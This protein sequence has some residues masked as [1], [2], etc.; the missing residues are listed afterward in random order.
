MKKAHTTSQRK[1]SRYKIL[2]QISKSIPR[3]IL[4]AF[5][6]MIWSVSSVYA[7][8]KPLT[9]TFAQ[10][11][12]SHTIR[13]NQTQECKESTTQMQKIPAWR[14]GYKLTSE[15]ILYSALD[16]RCKLDSSTSYNLKQGVIT[17]AQGDRIEALAENG[18]FLYIKAQMQGS[19]PLFGYIYKQNAILSV[20]NLDFYITFMCMVGVLIVGRYIISKSRFLRDYNI[21]EPVIGGIVVAVLILCIYQFGHIEFKFDSSLRDP[22]MLAFFSSIG[23][24]AD[25]ASLRKGGKM[26]C[27][28]LVAVVGLLALQ[29]IIGVSVASAM[30]VNPLIGMLGGSITMSGGHGTGAAWAEAFRNKYHLNA[31]LEVAMAC[32]TFGLIMGGIIGGPVARFLIKHY[33]LKTPGIKQDST[34]GEMFEMPAKE[35]L[36]TPISFVESLALIA[37]CLLFGNLLSDWAKLM[38]PT[39]NLPTFVYCLFVGVLLRNVL[40]ALRIHQVFDR[41][42]SVLGNVSLSLFLAF[43]MMTLNLWELVALALPIVMILGAQVVVMVVY[44]ICITF[45]FCGKDYDA[46]VLAAGHCGFGLGAT[47]TAMVNMQAVTSH[48]GLSHTAFIIVPL[49]GAFFL[50]LINALVIQG[51][52][53]ILSLF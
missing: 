40:S 6:V 28:F 21:P 31:T 50:D 3:S 4:F 46:A 18:E 12:E 44:A 32:A 1:I 17:L 20:V 5:G 23:L 7:D 36:I 25:F 30:G 47:P 10:S 39:F 14:N 48:Y 15:A 35:R 33:K 9:Q 24:S 8:T 13:A 16:E 42:M 38:L 45:R 27:V 53:W 22:L 11:L 19:A 41:E 43:A 29:N 49:V 2:A 51:S 34:T 37:L 52:L 26:F